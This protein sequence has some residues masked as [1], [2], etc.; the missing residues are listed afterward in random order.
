MIRRKPTSNKNYFK[1]FTPLSPKVNSH[2]VSEDTRT[3]SSI[4]EVTISAE[5]VAKK[6]KV[7]DKNKACGLDGIHPANYESLLTIFRSQS[8]K[9]LTQSLKDK[10]LPVDWKTAVISPIFKKGNKNIAANYRPISL[11]SI[12]CKIMES[13][14]ICKFSNNDK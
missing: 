8:Q 12:I 5:M 7:L 4:P 11:T 13:G 3:T 1:V 6:I 9:T 14:E 2:K 10:M